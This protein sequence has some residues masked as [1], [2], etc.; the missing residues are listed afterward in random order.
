MKNKK[1]VIGLI[2]VILIIGSIIAMPLLTQKNKKN[3]DAE[4]TESTANLESQ[5]TKVDSY[6]GKLSDG[7]QINTNAKMNQS[8]DLGNLQLTNIRLTLKNGVTTFRATVKNN[9]E[10]KTD[11]KNV[12]LTLKN[13][14]DENMVSVA[15][16]IPPIDPQQT[17]E[18]AI[19]VTSNYINAVTYDIVE[20]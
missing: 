7:S 1:E 4:N 5:I 16:V 20:Q 6:I 2:V 13:E 11:L 14:N 10:T 8:K 17:Q 3:P 9:G 19:S 12:M 18:L 15:G